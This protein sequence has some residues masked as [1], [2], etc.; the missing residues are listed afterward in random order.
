LWRFRGMDPGLRRSLLLQR[1]PRVAFRVSQSR[2]HPPTPRCCAE[3]EER[4]TAKA[5]LKTE[6][7]CHRFALS[8]GNERPRFVRD[9]LRSAGIETHRDG[10]DCAGCQVEP[11]AIRGH[12][13]ARELSRKPGDLVGVGSHVPM[14]RTRRSVASVLPAASVNSATTARIFA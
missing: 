14:A 1:A 9:T 5:A 3:T 4:I 8:G 10:R 2:A 7:T 11:F 12:C 13:A 6:F